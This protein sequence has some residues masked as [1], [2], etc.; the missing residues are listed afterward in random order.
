MLARP[1]SLLIFA[2]PIQGKLSHFGVNTVGKL[3]EAQA[4]SKVCL[5]LISRYVFIKWF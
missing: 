1:L 2:R 5:S 4:A 3:N